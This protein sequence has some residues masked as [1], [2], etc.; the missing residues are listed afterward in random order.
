MKVLL[1]FKFYLYFMFKETFKRLF[2]YIKFYCR[3][4]FKRIAFVTINLLIFY[5]INN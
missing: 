4:I 2:F 5:I 3:F 1:K